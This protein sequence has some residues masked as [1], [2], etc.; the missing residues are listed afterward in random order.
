MNSEIERHTVQPRTPEWFALRARDLTASEVGAVAGV[1]PWK[2]PYSVWAEKMGLSSGPEENS[3]MT[4][5][6]W[7]EPAVH[8]AFNEQHPEFHITYP[9]DL[10][11]RDP[12]LRL[13]G[14]PD[15]TG[16][17]GNWPEEPI[18]F[19]FKVIS[20]QSYERSWPG[21]QPPMHY[22][23]QVAT[24]A[25]LLDADH[26]ILAALVL[27][28]QE[29]ELVVHRID[30]HPTAEHWIRDI[31]RR[32]WLAFDEGHAPAAPDYQ[33][34]ADVLRQVFRP[35]REKPAPVDLSGD[36]RLAEVL[37]DREYVRRTVEDGKKTI[38]AYDAE[39]IEK[40]NGSEA[41]VHGG[42][43]IAHTTTHVAEQIR[44]AYSYSQL[45]ITAPKED[46]T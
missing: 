17:N 42:W 31:A 7:C 11:V 2:T 22:Q 32:F 38:K 14:T 16:F 43:K 4:L 20:R 39:I 46:A 40:L 24:N 29:A 44:A 18:A 1:D 35:D 34:D 19:E 27:G 25:M 45:R 5:G 8:F 41:A 37:R 9:L 21:G 30:R 13:G 3:A 33:R 28:Y 23:L 26:S 6:R 36:N 10:Y 15:A 12:S